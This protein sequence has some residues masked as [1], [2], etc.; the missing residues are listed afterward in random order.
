MDNYIDASGYT[1]IEQMNQSTGSNQSRGGGS[2]IL[3]SKHLILNGTIYSDGENA[4]MNEESGGGS[5]GSILII[6]DNLYCIFNI[7]NNFL[8]L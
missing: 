7:L 6:T 3:I 5:G 4:N 8:I 1:L 2:V